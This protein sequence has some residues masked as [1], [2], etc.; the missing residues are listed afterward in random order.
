MNIVQQKL[1]NSYATLVIAKATALE[2]VPEVKV[3][4]GTEY[5]IRSE[6]EIEIARRTVASL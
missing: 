1:V 4:G 3:I 2:D 6:V 5:P